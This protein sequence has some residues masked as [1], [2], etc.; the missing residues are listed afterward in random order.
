MTIKIYDYVII[1]SGAGGGPLAYYLTKAGKTV[2]MLEAGKAWAAEDYPDNELHGN[3]ELAWNG[4]MDPTADAATVLIRGKVLGGGT[5]LNQA[6]LDRF[7]DEAFNS[8]AAL[9]GISTFSSSQMARHYEAVESQLALHT[10]TEDE[11]NGNAHI[12]VQGFE[13]LGYGWAPLRRGQ[14]QCNVEE[15]N[16][17]ISC[18]TGCRRASK[19]SMV[20]NF[21]PKAQQQG[22]TIVTEC[23]VQGVVHGSH[24][25][26]IH[27]LHEGESK[28]FYAK[29]CVLSAGAI[30]STEILLKS[31]YQHQL[32]ALGKGFYC[33]P[34]QMTFALYDE[35]VDAHKGSFQAVKSEEPRFRE[36]GFKLEN[37]FAGPVGVGFLLPQ[38][39]VEHQDIMAA[40]RHLAC[41]EVAVRDVTP[42]H[43]KL[44]RKGRLVIQKKMGRPERAR[45]KAGLEVI[46][47]V[48][49]ATGAKRVLESPINI[50]VHLMGGCAQGVDYR[51]SVVN[52]D[53]S[54][55]GLPRLHVVDGSLYPNAPGINPSLTIMALA[56]Q[57]AERLLQEELG[58]AQ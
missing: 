6:L 29:Q 49:A 57:A 53:F 23:H 55:H 47:E 40:Y 50:S 32:P 27:A 22:L 41:I 30:G 18:L 24:H 20:N 36:Q 44:N 7:D 15:G 42:G 11:R 9:S 19:Q 1:G 56:H 28:P 39:G 10:I 51:N 31:G 35:P 8:W 4:G 26:T 45:A 52:P 14:S 17:C 34:Q 43:I 54:V 13:E 38:I 58:G 46:K 16:D 33:H 37:V 5:V 48:Y 3:S 12:Y 21:L 2:L 25:V